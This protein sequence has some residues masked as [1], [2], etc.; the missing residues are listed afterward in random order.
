MTF[1]EPFLSSIDSLPSNVVFGDVI[2]PPGGTY[3]PR[4]Q[5]NYQ[6]F[7]VQHGRVTV[8]VDDHELRLGTGEMILLTPGHLEFFE[9]AD[10]VKTRHSWCHFDWPVSQ[11]TYEGIEAFTSKIQASARIE[12]LIALGLSI[13]H[14]PRSLA[15]TLGHLAATIFWEFASTTRRT[16]THLQN[17]TLPETLTCV[18][19]YIAQHYANTLS[20]RHL[21]QVASLTPEHLSRTFRKH[22]DTTPMAYLW[23]V[24]ARQGLLTLRHTGL[25]VEEIA[26]QCGFKSAAHFSR[27]LKR[28]YGQTPSQLRKSYRDVATETQ[29]VNL[30]VA[31]AMSR[32]P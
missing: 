16:G 11:V 30:E 24:R 18:Q 29:G 25:S 3:G 10:E 19:T 8:T 2:Y 7:L 31:T 14:D 21:A 22:L 1:F 4:M 20:L 13:Y 26:Y 17:V 28:L 27:K 32:N 9:F 12:H 6:L 23:Q 15:P 5:H